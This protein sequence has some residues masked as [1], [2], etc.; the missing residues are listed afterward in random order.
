MSNTL[1][2]IE[3]AALRELI[4]EVLRES[5]DQWSPAPEYLDSKQ[6][7]ALVGLHPKTLAALARR[8]EIPGVRVGRAWRFR[9]RD[10][11]I[12]MAGGEVP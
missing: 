6:G 9:R 3:A 8:G 12:F 1:V 11:E 10:L 7:A 4:R 2:L 5:F